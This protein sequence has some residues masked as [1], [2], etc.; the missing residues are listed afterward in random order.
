MSLEGRVSIDV[1]GGQRPI[2]RVSF[3]QPGDVARLV[4]GKSPDVAVAT[5]ARVFSLCA[6]AQKQAARLALDAAEG[7]ER[8]RGARAALQCLTEM[9]SLRENSLRIALDWPRALAEQNDP[10]QL[11]SLMSLVP[12]IESVIVSD[13]VEG[14]KC[15]M[16]R[17]ACRTAH[18]VVA[19][20]DAWLASVVFGEP[21]SQWQTRQSA[22]DVLSWAS[23]GRTAAARMLFRIHSRGLAAAGAIDV[24]SLQPLKPCAAEAWL[25]GQASDPLPTLLPGDGDMPETTLLSRHA[26]DSR[27]HTTTTAGAAGAG[28]WARLTARL[29]ELSNLPGRMRD[30]IED[31]VE[32]S[33][34][35]RLGSGSGMSEIKAARGTLIHAASVHDGRITRYRVLPPTRWN[36]HARGATARAVGRIAAAHGNDA[37]WLAELMVDAIDPCV[38]YSVRIH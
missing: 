20:A 7:R 12:E 5:V 26:S 22:H 17:A 23:E 18:A 38:A 2:V 1:S 9:E 37:Q 8:S 25:A 15:G 30:L 19:R 6:R 35:R 31:Q 28:L 14:G 32:P 21:V 16:S 11:K 13:P 3:S 33:V 24:R 10:A 29:I 36:F 4:E 27:L 34:G